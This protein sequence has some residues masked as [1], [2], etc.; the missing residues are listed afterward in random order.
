MEL[1]HTT[2]LPYHALCASKLRLM[3]EPRYIFAAVDKLI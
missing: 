3:A 2:A 1:G